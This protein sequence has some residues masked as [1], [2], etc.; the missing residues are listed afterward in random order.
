MNNN[1]DDDDPTQTRMMRTDKYCTARYTLQLH[2]LPRPAENTELKFVFRLLLLLLLLFVMI[3]SMSLALRAWFEI[4]MRQNTKQFS[5]TTVDDF[6]RRYLISILYSG[7]C[8]IQ[9]ERN[10]SHRHRVDLN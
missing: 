2:T 10:R 1:D 8:L 7:R 6:G 5:H 4:E 3:K 9:R